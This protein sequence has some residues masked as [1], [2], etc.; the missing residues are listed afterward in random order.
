MACPFFEPRTKVERDNRARLPLLFEFDGICHAGEPEIAPEHRFRLCN[1][2]NVKG[3]CGHFPSE[4]PVSAIRFT[5]SAESENS[6]A[7]LLIEECDYWPKA[8]QP[9]EFL[10]HERALRPEFDDGCRRAQALQFCTS[11]LEKRDERK[12]ANS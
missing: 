11:Y 3:L 2:G 10:I 12:S 8:W 5:V 1:H 7:V 6:L 4:H 9:F